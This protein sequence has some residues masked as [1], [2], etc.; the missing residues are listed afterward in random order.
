[1]RISRIQAAKMWG[2]LFKWTL[3]VL[4]L[5]AELEKDCKAAAK[6]NRRMKWRAWKITF[7]RKFIGW[8][9]VDRC[10]TGE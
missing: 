10:L 1:M 6:M 8:R 3:D 9:E 4:H 2:T 7:L 5:K